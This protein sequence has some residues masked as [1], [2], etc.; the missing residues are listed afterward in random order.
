MSFVFRYGQSGK[1]DLEVPASTLVAACVPQGVEPILDIPA[2]VRESISQPIDFPP[3]SRATVPGDQVVIALEPG[4]PHAAEIVAALVEHLCGA[5]ASADHITVLRSLPLGAGADD[6]R[7]RLAPDTRRAVRLETHEPDQRGH[8]G[9]LAATPAGRPIYLNRSLCDADLVIPVGCLRCDWSIGYHGVFS[10]L[11][12]TFSDTR[13]LQ[14]FRNPQAVAA[15]TS[16][17]AKAQHEVEAVAWLAGTQFVVQ[18]LPGPDD[19]LLA[20]FAGEAERVFEQGLASTNRTWNFSVPRR[21]SLVVAGIGG[22]QSWDNI[23]RALA[24]AVRVV[25]D[26]GAILLCTELE[27]P[28]GPAVAALAGDDLEAALRRI[29]KERA[30]DSTA[31]VALASA[32]SAARVYLLSHLSDESVDDVGIAAVSSPGEVERLIAR[33]PTCILLPDAQFAVPTC[34]S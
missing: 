1:I 12:P 29:E 6:P 24:S 27:T 28:P 20:I 31:A 4:V 8:L 23:A 3:L 10:G 9:Y 13:T 17:H 5:G 16:V 22:Q 26:G 25:A 32:Q 11:Y 34:A 14:R 33:H 15:H 21:A 7:S 18:V 2:A 30:V 19:S